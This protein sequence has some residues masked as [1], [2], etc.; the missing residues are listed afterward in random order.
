MGGEDSCSSHPTLI[1]GTGNNIDIV[2]KGLDGLVHLA[3]VRGTETIIVLESSQLMPTTAR[4]TGQKLTVTRI[5]R[6]LAADKAAT[7]VATSEKRILEEV[8]K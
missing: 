5:L 8:P 7:E 2:T 1:R 4:V 6:A 3:D